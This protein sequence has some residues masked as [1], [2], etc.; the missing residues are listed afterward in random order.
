MRYQ[1]V[2]PRIA[3]SRKKPKNQKSGRCHHDSRYQLCQKVSSLTKLNQ[4]L[5]KTFT[6]TRLQ[7]VINL[8]NHQLIIRFHLVKPWKKTMLIDY[9]TQAQK[10]AN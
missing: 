6:R 3:T 2:H 5:S 4:T 7:L 10:H 9:L 8:I 1:L